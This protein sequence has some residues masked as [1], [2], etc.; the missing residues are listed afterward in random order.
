MHSPVARTAARV[1]SPLPEGTVDVAIVG[2]GLGGL[3]AGAY[4]ARQGLRV[5]LFDSHYVA[6]GCATMFERGRSD[7]RYNFDVGLHYIGDCGPDGNIPR[8]LRP[9]GI[10]LQYVEMDPD[11]FDTIV[12]PDLS[13]R[14]PANRDLYRDRLVAQFPKEKR[15]IDRYVRF[16]AE[17]ERISRRMERQDGRM[18]GRTL[19]DVALHGRLLARYQN[20]TIATL[21]DSCTQDQRL[22]AVMLGQSGD[23]GLP[24]SKVS[25]LLHAGLANHY[26]QGAYYPKG[27]GQV[28]SDALAAEIEAQGGSIHLRCGIEKILIED[29][30]AVG[31]RTEARKGGQQEIRAKVVISNADI[32][33]TMTD[34]IG[35]ERLP[36]PWVSRTETM[37]MGG[38]IFITF[39]GIKVD[40][41]ALGMG[42]SNYWCYDGYDFESFYSDPYDSEGRVTTRGCYITSASLK[43]PGT[44]GHA[45][46]GIT[47]VEVMTLVPG[48]AKVWG[49]DPATIE[50]GHYRKDAAY[51]ATKQRIEDDLI[52]RLDALFPGSGAA[53]VFAESATP[54]SHTRYTRAT[55]GTGYGLAC[56]PAQ[57]L[58]GRPGYRGPVDGLY[59]AGAS[60]RAGHG[61]VG[62][63][64][65]GRLAALR[66]ASDLD[67][68]LT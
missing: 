68:P 19:L 26:F 67:R 50:S 53:V 62:A 43:D 20:A 66:V 16:L 51:L 42:A 13:F 29:G 58:K 28:I 1:R 57:F 55:D 18:G 36:S 59:L 15:G 12:L 30:R 8:L 34:L 54:V 17:V 37:E 22:R 9:L 52:A 46:E 48:A 49:V 23:Y 64:T 11:G 40:M 32:K 63:M 2:C 33:R 47:S 27:G 3:T 10:E 61:I 41:A 38:A 45:P 56:T 44:P 35:V 65:S 21:L 31:V 25:A 5:A 4:L 24:P 39:L 7:N 14:I 60:T 6:G